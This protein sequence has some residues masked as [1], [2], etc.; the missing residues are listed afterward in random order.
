MFNI[1]MPI[2]SAA[3]SSIIS[4]CIAGINPNMDSCGASLQ[5]I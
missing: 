1:I 2:N 4:L 3:S 5:N